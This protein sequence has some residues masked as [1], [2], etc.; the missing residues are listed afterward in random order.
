MCFVCSLSLLDS[1]GTSPL[2]WPNK[3]RTCSWRRVRRGR[4]PPLPALPS[5]ST[6][7]SL[8]SSRGATPPLRMPTFLADPTVSAKYLWVSLTIKNVFSYN[9]NLTLVDIYIYILQNQLM[10]TITWPYTWHVLNWNDI[11]GA[12]ET[13]SAVPCSQNFLKCHW[14]YRA[15]SS[16]HLVDSIGQIHPSPL[17]APYVFIHGFNSQLKRRNSANVA[18]RLDVWICILIINNY[19]IRW[20]GY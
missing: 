19:C 14:L 17:L 6:E 3:C 9:K 4:D 18:V 7:T 20:L 15:R 1:T 2:E 10:L 11:S 5:A 13:V 16:N 12:H 8:R